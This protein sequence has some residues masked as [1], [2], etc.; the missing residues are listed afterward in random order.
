MIPLQ[1]Y[2]DYNSTVFTYLDQ[3]NATADLNWSIGTPFNLDD[4]FIEARDNKSGEVTWST[5]YN[6][7]AFDSLDN[8]FFAK[9]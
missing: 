8:Q 7:L 2:S 9:L 6:G 1:M 5:T 3:Q 4:L